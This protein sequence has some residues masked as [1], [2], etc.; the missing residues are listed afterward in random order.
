MKLK[1]EELEFVSEW[2]PRPELER[3]EIEA[4]AA[5]LQELGQLRPIEVV[6]KKDRWLVSDGWRRVLA[7]KLLRREEIEGV[8]VPDDGKRHLVNLTDVIQRQA[9]TAI[10]EA[11]A[12]RRE[13]DGG[14]SKRVLANAL[15]REVRW[16]N[17]RVEMA[18]L[19][20]I[21]EEKEVLKEQTPRQLQALRKVSKKAR[22]AV[23]KELAEEARGLTP[24][25]TG[26]AAKILERTPAMP[27]AEAV[28]QA[29]ETPGGGLVKVTVRLPSKVVDALERAAAR[30]GM[31]VDGYVRFVVENALAGQ[32]ALMKGMEF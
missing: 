18:K 2:N 6:R 15:G 28:A 8:E 19:T 7:T 23:V 5:S 1:V 16:V 14:T 26:K 24:T 32:A 13:L 22:P 11:L 12:V 30:F 31:K 10:E 3:S 9:L 27:V 29:K 25:Q 21:V 17:S 20:E 4:L